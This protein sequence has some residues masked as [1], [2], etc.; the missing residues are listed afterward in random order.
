[1]P[2]DYKYQRADAENLKKSIAVTPGSFFDDESGTG[3]ISPKGDMIV[4]PKFGVQ[5]S[6]SDPDGEYG[7]IRFKNPI[8][9][10][11]GYRKHEAYDS[12]FSELPD[13]LKK[14]IA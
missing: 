14:K 10:K 5:M 7:G 4:S 1:V 8:K 2:N 9:K 11:G 3:A 13:Q 12:K 6:F